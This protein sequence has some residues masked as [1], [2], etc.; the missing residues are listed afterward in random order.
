VIKQNQIINKDQ[1]IIEYING[2]IRIF[3]NDD[4]INECI[5]S[6]VIITYGKLK[7]DGN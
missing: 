2:I 5:L 3:P 4:Q 1:V 6:D 7:E